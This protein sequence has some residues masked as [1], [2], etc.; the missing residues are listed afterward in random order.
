MKKLKNNKKK[1][2][3]KSAKILSK[4]TL[5]LNQSRERLPR[6]DDIKHTSEPKWSIQGPMLSLKINT[7]TPGPIYMPKDTFTKSQTPKWTIKFHIKEP[8]NGLFA[9]SPGPIY[10]PKYEYTKPK[11]TRNYTLHSRT[12]IKS[13]KD[14]MPSPNIYDPRKSKYFKNVK[15]YT[16]KGRITNRN[17]VLSDT[18]GPT[19][20]NLNNSMRKN[21]LK[22]IKIHNK[23]P[24]YTTKYKKKLPG[25][26]K[27]YP[28]MNYTRP[29]TP[30]WSLGS[31]ISVPNVHDDLPGPG[32]YGPPVSM[33]WKKLKGKKKKFKKKKAPK[34]YFKL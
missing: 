3:P 32:S 34:Y 12:Y 24:D 30:K 19:D 21:S 18:P 13:S 23:L 6:I 8:H 27:Y 29:T 2:R 17:D 4:N 5:I 20:Y 14:F 15:D 25:P 22:T 31:R 9:D 10:N 26:A 16:I 33:S 11:T 7:D 28:R 1:I